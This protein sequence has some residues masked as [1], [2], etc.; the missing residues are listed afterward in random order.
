MG[1]LSY[2]APEA[3]SGALVDERADIYS[4][5]TIT[6]WL[7]TGQHP[8]TGRLARDLFRQ[9]LT[10]PPV[11]LT[12]AVPGLRFPAALEAAVMRGLERDPQARQ[13]TVLAFAAEVA[14]GAAGDATSASRPGLLD[15][16]KRA[17]RRDKR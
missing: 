12:Q 2:V 3:L 13:P 5:A 17:V 9:L 10:M 15:A 16:L 7:L 1:T 11:P 14:A 8:Y 4:L 6:Y